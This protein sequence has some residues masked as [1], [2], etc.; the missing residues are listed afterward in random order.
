MIVTTLSRDPAKVNR[1]SRLLKALSNPG[2]LAIVDLLL[3]KHQLSVNEIA[4]QTQLSQSHASQH[5][6]Q[7]EEIGLLI[8]ERDGKHM[9]YRIHNQAISQLLACINKCADC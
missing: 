5:L 1:I 4:E 8:S 9:Y 7:L 3:E 6:K 2:R